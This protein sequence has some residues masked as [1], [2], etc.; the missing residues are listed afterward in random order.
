MTNHERRIVELLADHRQLMAAAIARE[1]Y[2]A[3]AAAPEER[4]SVVCN[5]YTWPVG[6]PMRGRRPIHDYR[7]DHYAEAVELYNAAAD[8]EGRIEAELI[9]MVA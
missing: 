2:A 3:V 8:V 1:C 5:S 9:T 6:S 7:E 4:S